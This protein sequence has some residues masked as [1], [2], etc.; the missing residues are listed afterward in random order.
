MAT[1]MM[2][3]KR[4]GVR[5]H[6]AYLDD[7]FVGLYDHGDDTIY[8]QIGLTMAETKE[9]LAHELAHAFYRHPCSSGRNERQADSRAALLLID[10][11]EYCTAERINPDPWAIA[12]ELGI[13]VEVVRNYQK[14]CLAS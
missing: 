3:A 10:P 7:P 2:E 6:L 1:L 11:G 12:E 5:V 8:I 14:Y 4:L 9:T 13:T